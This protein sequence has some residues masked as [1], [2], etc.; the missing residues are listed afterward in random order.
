MKATQKN[1]FIICDKC[2]AENSSKAKYCYSCGYELPANLIERIDVQLNGRQEF[3]YTNINYALK[4]FGVCFGLLILSLVVLSPLSDII[5]MVLYLLLGFTIPVIVFFLFKKKI[6]RSGKGEIV[7]KVL[8]L[9]MDS[10]KTTIDLSN[11]HSFKVEHF[12]GTKLSL[13]MKNRKKL[14][15]YANDNFCDSTSFEAFTDY[16]ETCLSDFTKEG[17]VN[18][19]RKKSVFEQKWMFYFLF[20]MTILTAGAIFYALAFTD[21]T[22]GTLFTSTGLLIF[23][24][25]AYFKAQKKKVKK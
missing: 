22:P 9:E 7:N 2:Q 25:A 13:R 18:I 20:V 1:T 17:N 4:L 19:I 11:I 23:M 15:I 14:N 3:I 12:N 5:G 10:Q 21:R 24:W 8:H 6:K 16:F